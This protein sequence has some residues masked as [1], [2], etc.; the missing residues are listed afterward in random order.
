MCRLMSTCTSL[1]EETI[2]LFEKRFERSRIAVA[3]EYDPKLP[4][5]QGI[6]D[7]LH[8]VLLNLILNGVTAM[9]KGGTLTLSTTW[10]ESCNQVQL[11]I[12]D[13]GVGISPDVLPHIFEPFYTSRPDGHGL[14]LPVSYSIIEKHQGQITV[15]SAPGSGSTFTIILPRHLEP[16]R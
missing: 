2:K 13:N 11:A 14:G 5:I 6:S 15:E 8:Q 1:L 7:Q 3:R 10:D 12:K 4:T 9:P 16:D